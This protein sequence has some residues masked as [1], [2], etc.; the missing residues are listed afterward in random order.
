M[1]VIEASNVNTLFATYT[2]DWFHPKKRTTGVLHNFYELDTTEKLSRCKSAFANYFHELTSM[3]PPEHWFSEE[4]FPK[5]FEEL[6]HMVGELSTTQGSGAR[7]LTLGNAVVLLAAA[8][9]EN[10]ASWLQT[11]H[12]NKIT[13]E[14][15]PAQQKIHA[16]V[17]AS[18]LLSMFERLSTDES[19]GGST[20]CRV[21]LSENV[22]QIWF[23]KDFTDESN[24]R[25][26]LIYNT[27]YL[28][29][30]DPPSNVD[31]AYF[32]Y[33]KFLV[34]SAINK[35]G[36]RE[37]RCVLNFHPLSKDEVTLRPQALLEVVPCK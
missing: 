19:S 37:S 24:E 8:T 9:R 34:E 31:K 35:C 23:D 16:T 2:E 30:V 17:A 15:L 26:S 14:I 36:G 11:I 7:N 22:L 13:D 12:W 25:S 21:N 10:S 6:K 1:Q 29:A 33:R 20:I 28:P 27:I 3:A 4:E 32:Y 18:A 5:L